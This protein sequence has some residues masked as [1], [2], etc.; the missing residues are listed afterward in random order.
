MQPHGTHGTRKATIQLTGWS[1][2]RGGGCEAELQVESDG[3]DVVPV[4]ARRARAGSKDPLEA[5]AAAAPEDC[6]FTG[7]AVKGGT[8]DR[9]CRV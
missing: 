4:D 7:T 8:G 1:E 2:R 5:P 3:L 9:D 6:R